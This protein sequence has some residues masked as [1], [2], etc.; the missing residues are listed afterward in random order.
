M[1]GVHLLTCAWFAAGQAED[2]G[3]KDPNLAPPR[4]GLGVQGFKAWE[5]CFR[6]MNTTTKG[7]CR[8]SL[9]RYCGKKG[10]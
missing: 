10:F 1:I 6:K 3:Q 9:E 8:Y 5:G 7:N 2:A 4:E